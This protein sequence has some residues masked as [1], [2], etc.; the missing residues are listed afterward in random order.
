MNNTR[1]CNQDHELITDFKEIQKNEKRTLIVVVLTAIMMVGEIVAGYA[2]GS[3]A[4]LADGYHMASHAG[5]LGIAYFVYR[6]ARS[7]KMKNY[8]TFGTGKLLPLGGYSSALGLGM[9]AVW[10]IYESIE[11]MFNPIP[12]EFNEAIIIAAIGLG[13]NLVSAWILGGHSHGHAHDDHDHEHDHHD[14][15]HDHDH[16]HHHEHEHK[17]NNHVHDHNHQSALMH[18]LADAMTSVLAIAALFIGKYYS[19]LW[20]D[21]LIGVVG[22]L[23][24]IKWAYGLCKETAWELLD[25]HAKNISVDD[26]KIHIEKEG[27][28]VLDLHFWKVGPGNYSCQ[29]IVESESLKGS[30]YYRD[31]LSHR[32]SS[33]HLIVE[34]RLVS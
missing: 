34:E 19:T 18:V 23:V 6:L 22:A 15:E 27:H 21:P 12:I 8:F 1:H 3:M 31:L 11:R 32:L 13:V 4:L 30:D 7:P 26:I 16:D 33:T 28:K 14:H 17:H 9:I 5:A 29:I 2:T 10:M 25:G 20:L 24:I